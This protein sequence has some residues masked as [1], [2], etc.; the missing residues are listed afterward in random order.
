MSQS[1]TKYRWVILFMVYIC[2]LV[3]A[4]TL[5]FLPPI[6]PTIIANFQLSHTQAGL[7]MSLFTLP[8]IFLAIIAGLLSDRWGTYKVGLFSFFLIIIGMLTFVLSPTFV[9]AGLGRTIAGAG[10]VTLTIVAAIILSQ[11]FQGREVG[12]AMGIYNTA[13]PVGSIIC[14]STF[15]KLAVQSGWQMPVFITVG[16]GLLGLFVFRLLFRSAPNLS[17]M[18]VPNKRE[19]K[20][21]FSNILHIAGLVWMAALCWLLF[22]AA[23]IS[24]STFAPD[25]FV[26]KGETIGHAGFLTSLLM[27]GSLALSPIIGRLIDKFNSNSIFI[28]AGGSILAVSLVFVSKTTNFLPPMAVMAVAVAFVPTPVFSYLS[29]NLPPKDLG[30]GFGILG[31]VS[32]IGMFFGPSLSGL[33]RDKTGSYEMAFL[34]LAV[35]SLLITAAAIIFQARAKKEKK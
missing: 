12:S 19:E 34:F 21:I 15:G 20:T 31:M 5:Q 6:L 2:M 13:M 35:L 4:F 18:D 28:G 26:S 23:V 25:F 11:W 32:G 1:K 7:L 14:F 33:I 8:S 30:V 10:A 27:W 16:V 3:F 24:F 29:K 17:Q 9:L 22:N